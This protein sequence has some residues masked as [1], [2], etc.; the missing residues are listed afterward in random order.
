MAVHTVGSGFTTYLYSWNADLTALENSLALSGSGSYPLSYAWTEVLSNGML[1]S[2]ACG[3]P[4]AGAAQLN[5]SIPQASSILGVALEAAAPGA[6]VRI[7]TAGKF[8]T[9]Q[10]FTSP[11]FDRRS[12][13][14]PGT[15]GMA[16]GNMAILGGLS[17]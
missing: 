8:A 10:S 3:Q 14:P 6:A 17:D 12:A 16:I 15:R 11:V 4:S 2:V 1:A 9:N 13:T 7:A 5:V